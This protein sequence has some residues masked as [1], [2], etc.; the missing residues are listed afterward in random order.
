MFHSHE[1]GAGVCAERKCVFQVT[2]AAEAVFHG[3]KLGPFQHISRSEGS[4]QIVAVV[5]ADGCLGTGNDADVLFGQL[6]QER[7][8]QLFIGHSQAECMADGDPALHTGG[9]N[10]L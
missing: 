10:P 2:V 3:S 4:P 1:S 5:V 6:L 8:A 9:A 7:A